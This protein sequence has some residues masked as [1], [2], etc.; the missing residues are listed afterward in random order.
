M[1]KNILWILLDLVFIVVFNVVF[2]VAGGTSYPASVWI[3]YAFIHL[4]YLMLL[5]TPILTRKSSSAA[6]FGFSLFTISSVY[7]IVEFIVGLVFIL[8]K[9]DTVK[10]ALIVQVI[11]AGIYLIILLSNLIANEN[12]A[13]S[14]ERHEQEV[15]YIKQAT[16]RVKLLQDKLDSKEANRKI[17]EAYDALHSSP[18][19]TADTVRYTEASIREAVTDLEEAVRAKD[20]ATAIAKAQ[21]II[22]L[23]E[24]RNLNL[25]N[26]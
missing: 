15:A 14:V 16:S 8:I 18:T 11:I 19:K 22:S 7:F 5:A 1:K 26:T 6:V 12:T 24:E 2:F 17:E 25:R 10:T 23:T 4:A 13:D 20:E 21:Q 9:Q 3:S